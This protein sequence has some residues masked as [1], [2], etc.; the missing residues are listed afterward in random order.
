MST[1]SGADGCRG[2][3]VVLTKDLESGVISWR[4]AANAHDLI[5]SHPTP[6]ITALDIPIGL[7]EH[8][9]RE[10]DLMARQLLGPGRAGSVFPA[11]IRPIL[12]AVSYEEACEISARIDRKK[13]SRQTYGIIPKIRDIDAVL[14][15]DPK[16]QAR[17]R[18]V[19]PEICFYHLAGQ[20]PLQHSKKKP[21]GRQERYELLYPIFGHWLQAALSERRELSSQEDD[22]LDAF[23]ALW[24]AE[25]IAMNSFHVIPAS[26]P[27][28]SYGLCMEIVA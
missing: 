3:W 15:Q 13:I 5:Y 26:P 4:L 24:T 7:T 9:P 6:E 11:P 16:L 25:R 17:V 18:E 1:I 12:Y 23:A 10:C 14:R 27:R 22:V 28:D 21:E 19:H 8:G 20:R 2:G